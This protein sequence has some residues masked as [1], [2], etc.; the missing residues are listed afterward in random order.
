MIAMY[1]KVKRGGSFASKINIRVMHFR[2][3]SKEGMACGYVLV[4]VKKTSFLGGNILHLS[5]NVTPPPFVKHL[6]LPSGTFARSK[7][8][9]ILVR[10]DFNCFNFYSIDYNIDID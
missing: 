1:G 3:E 4:W 5:K 8:D 9:L 7:V 10:K 2:M 6:D